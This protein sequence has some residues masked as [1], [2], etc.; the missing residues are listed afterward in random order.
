MSRFSA[1]PNLEVQK[2]LQNP[3][4]ADYLKNLQG[5][6]GKFEP[7]LVEIGANVSYSTKHIVVVFDCSGSTLN[8]SG[9]YGQG[10]FGFRGS[11]RGQPDPTTAAASAAADAAASAA[12]D[13]AADAVAA[14]AAAA[15]M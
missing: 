15:A 9:S 6:E 1:D 5:R 3:T 11:M 7:V 4:Y 14:A 13:A 12:A 2:D 8:G 10:S